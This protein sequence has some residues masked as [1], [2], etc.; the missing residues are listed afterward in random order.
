MNVVV[1]I[2]LIVFF[3]FDLSLLRKQNLSLF[4]QAFY[5][6]R[7]VWAVYSVLILILV[8]IP[9]VDYSDKVSFY[10]IVFVLPLYI[11]K[12]VQFY[13]LFRMQEEQ[14]K[15][16]ASDFSLASD[17]FEIVLLWFVGLMIVA[18]L[19][20]GISLA[21][22]SAE[23][24]LSE[25]VVLSTVSFL[26][27][28][29]LIQK[30]L[31]QYP[32][33]KF[34]KVVGLRTNSQPAWKL[35][36]LPA[37]AGLGLAL[38]SSF[39]I[40]SRSIQPITP[41]SEVLESTTSSAVILAFLGAAILLA[42]FFE[43]IIF[44]GF[45]FHVINRFKGQGFAIC[46]IAILFGVM[47]FEQY[48]GDWLVMGVVMVLGFILT[49]FRSWTGSS[50]PSIVM[51]YIF[52]GTMTIIPI[53]M[54][55]SSSPIYFEY[56]MNY[57]QLNAEQK[58]KLLQESIKEYP[59][60]ADSYNDL[61]WLYAEENKNLE[62]ALILIEKALSFYPERYVFLDTKAEILYKLGRFEE[63]VT[64]EKALLEEHPSNDYLKNQVEKFSQALE[65]SL[66]Q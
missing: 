61:A 56:Q 35:Y 38:L 66:A 50:I 18:S 24:K 11:V 31:R 6:P 3:Y 12:R 9:D 47:H 10:L 22:A 2:A 20:K 48:W 5:L 51:H 13:K 16:E 32:E 63:A 7:W 4:Q 40:F 41:L 25:V 39:A 52:N 54:L 21:F 1:L 33:L 45:F 29:I 59:E 17:A 64:I 55:V 43:E 19:I 42:P 28:I 60:H 44:R 36:A 53:I 15:S 65:T 30:K 37:F 58:E 62:E 46:F 8:W 57:L 26:L 14:A 23:S 27:M 34:S 49:L